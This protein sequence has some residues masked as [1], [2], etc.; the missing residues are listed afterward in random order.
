M[1]LSEICEMSRKEVGRGGMVI[2][3]HLFKSVDIDH[4]SS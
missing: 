3:G 2:F 4:L 1:R